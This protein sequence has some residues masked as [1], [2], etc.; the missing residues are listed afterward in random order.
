[1]PVTSMS[2]VR[3]WAW[4]SI[5]VQACFLLSWRSLRRREATAKL[6]LQERAFAQIQPRRSLCP[7][8]SASCFRDNAASPASDWADEFAMA[9]GKTEAPLLHRLQKRGPNERLV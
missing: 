3:S 2:A 4:P 1:M 7:K 6:R 8:T 9:L 5:K